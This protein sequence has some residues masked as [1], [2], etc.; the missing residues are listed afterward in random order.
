M[1]MLEEGNLKIIKK[2]QSHIQKHH[3]HIKDCKQ[4]IVHLHEYPS[5]PGVTIITSKSDPKGGDLFQLPLEDY[6]TLMME[7]R[8]IAHVL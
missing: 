6:T 7:V 3:L 5:T 1:L 8:D 2:Q 4:C